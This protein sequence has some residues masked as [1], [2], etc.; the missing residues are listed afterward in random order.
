MTSFDPGQGWVK[1]CGVRSIEDARLCF[2]AGA[3]AVGINLWSESPRSVSLVQGARIAE[4][5]R[6]IGAVVCV[7][8]NASRAELKA[9]FEEV[10]PDFIQLHGEEEPGPTEEWRD[11]VFKAVGLGGA[12][13]AAVA[14]EWPGPFVLVD[15]R[16]EVARGGTGRAPPG[17]LVSQVCAY[18]PTVLAGGL[19]PEN[20]SL[21]IKRFRP[22][23]VDTASGVE[24]R[25]G[26]K[27]PDKVRR[28]VAGAREAFKELSR[29]GPVQNG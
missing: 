24:T 12:L 13:D 5:V 6:G 20:V 9:I 16:D 3:D 17:E 8:V 1:I 22:T 10:A 14:R 27:D 26:V 23:G 18:R 2:D 15:A 11:R 21:A 19:T 29:G 28:F 7:T 4:A 25:P